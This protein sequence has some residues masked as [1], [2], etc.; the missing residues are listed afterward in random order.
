MDV[1]L[2]R[3]RPD[4]GARTDDIARRW[5]VGIRRNVRQHVVRAVVV[6][7]HHH[8]GSVTAPSGRG[9]R[10]ADYTDDAAVRGRHDGR[11]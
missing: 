3:Y 6:A 10:I 11:T 2:A 4:A 8:R 7:Y 1:G 5:Q 9:V